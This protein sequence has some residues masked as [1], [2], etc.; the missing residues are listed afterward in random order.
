MAEVQKKKVACLFPKISHHHSELLQF[1]QLPH[2]SSY[3]HV[4]G[5]AKRNPFACEQVEARLAYEFPDYYSDLVEKINF[6]FKDS[7]PVSSSKE[8]QAWL[9]NGFRFLERK[10]RE[11]LLNTKFIC[12]SN[13][14]FVG[15]D[16]VVYKHPHNRNL[17]KEHQSQHNAF[18]QFFQTPLSICELYDELVKTNHEIVHQHTKPELLDK[19]LDLALQNFLY[20]EYLMVYEIVK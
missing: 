13:V 14:E 1:H 17:I 18:Y 2:L 10:T 20:D 12:H 4:I 3:I 7:V 15:E 19:F 6:K 16:E 8:R 11:D 9:F 5:Y